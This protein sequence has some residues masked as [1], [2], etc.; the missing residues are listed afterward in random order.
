MYKQLY[1]YEVAKDYSVFG[2][3]FITEP[4]ITK[5]LTDNYSMIETQI[6]ILIN[7]KSDVELIKNSIIKSQINFPIY[8][9]EYEDNF[10]INFTSDYE[11]W[12][13]DTEILNCFPEYEF[14]ENLEKGRKEIRLQMS[15]N[16]SEF[17]TDSWGRPIENPLN[18][19]KYLIKRFKEKLQKFNPKITVLFEDKEQD[20]YVNIVNG[21]NKGSGEKGFLLLNEFKS[22][23]D[24]SEVL[25]DKLYK[26]PI[27]AFHF[28]YLRMQDLV[29][30]DFEEYIKD[31]KKEIRKQ[32]RIPRK[33]V[34]D[35]IK[36]CNQNDIEGITK[37]LDENLIFEKT[38]KWKTEAVFN[39]IEEFKSYL[40]SANQDLC[41][42]EFKIRSSWDFKLP[43]SVAIRVKYFPNQNIKDNTTL[44]YRRF[45]FD[46][47]DD[48]IL[49]ITEEK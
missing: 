6:S 48:K 44:K 4:L 17:C 3:L 33:I 18:E 14:T 34:R 22:Q 47:Q 43:K 19:T 46:L 10:A 32:Q 27:E 5:R 9:C 36:A 39:G 29:N 30:N 15:R 1:I 45:I 16:Q 26:T 38:V 2:A 35:F 8:I 20:Y 13:L 28:G 7:R 41:E 40:K 25:K 31:K 12:E 23:D 21:I 24:K 37:Q 49:R 42:N 11:E